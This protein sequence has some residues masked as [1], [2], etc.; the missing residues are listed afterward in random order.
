MRKLV[1]ITGRK[2]SGKSTAAE[3]LQD[4]GFCTGSFIAPG[5]QMMRTLLRHRGVHWDEIQRMVEGDLKEVP[6]RHLNGRTPRYFMQTLGLEFGRHLIDEDLWV[7]SFRDNMNYIDPYDE[8][9]WVIADCRMPN[10]VEWLRERGFFLV[11]IVR[12]GLQ[13]KDKHG[14]ERYIDHL[15]THEIVVNN[16]ETAEE[17]KAHM[18]KFF[19]SQGIINT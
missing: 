11:K 16:F 1:A 19:I 13:D 6:S 12:P 8:M 4:R 9:N 2:R 5:K 3:V 10:E 7:D 18:E 17:F 14:T 15:L